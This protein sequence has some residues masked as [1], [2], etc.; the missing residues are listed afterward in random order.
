MIIQPNG[1]RGKKIF[2][3]NE[4]DGPEI[5]I[6]FVMDPDT[7]TVALVDTRTGVQVVWSSKGVFGLRDAMGNFIQSTPDG[8]IEI[9]A[10]KVRIVSEH[11]PEVIIL[12]KE[13]ENTEEATQA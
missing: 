12:K 2:N 10:S 3:P 5:P 1:G 8:A 13:E 6:N 11:N 4:P 9:V 7:G